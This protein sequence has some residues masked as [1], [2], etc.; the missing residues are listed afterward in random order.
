MTDVNADPNELNNFNHLANTWWDESGEFAALHKINPFRLEFMRQHCT[1]DGA[2]ALD[3][4][5]GGGILTESLYKAGAQATGLDLAEEVLTIARLHGLESGIKPTYLLE[6]AESHAE[7][8]AEHYDVVTC[9]EML[10]HVP[11]P[12][13]II[14]AASTCTKPNGW[15]FISTLNRNFK[16]YLLGIVAAEQVLNL[17]PTGTH[18]HDQFLKPSEVAEMARKVGLRLV[19]GAG[20][21]FNPLLNHYGLSQK[22]DVNYLLAFQKEPK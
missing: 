11:D 14:A 10:E 2:Q 13:S 16:S 5:C 18:T 21:T 22:M 9:M 1:L 12:E 17:V 6:S 7:Q 3:I 8:N 20:I 15:V 19:D 4:G